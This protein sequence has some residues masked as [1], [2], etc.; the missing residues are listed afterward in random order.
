MILYQVVHPF[1]YSISADTVNEAI[2]NFVK[3]HRNLNIANIIITDQKNNYEAKFNYFME[4]GRNKVGINHY[5]YLGPIVLGP[6]Y[7]AYLDTLPGATGTPLSPIMPA[8]TTSIWSSTV[9]YSPYG[10]PPSYF[11]S[12]FPT[13]VTLR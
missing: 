10:V 13:I 7:A 11:S 8:G 12:S 4:D 9:P 3:I 6:T 2:K 1:Q 5:P